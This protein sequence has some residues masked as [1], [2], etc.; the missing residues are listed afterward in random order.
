MLLYNIKEENVLYDYKPSYCLSIKDHCRLGKSLESFCASVG[1]SP[2]VI[3]QWYNEYP[4]FKDAIEMAPC[5]EL[6]YWEEQLLLCLEKRD[7]D[8]LQIIKSR[9]D[10][11]M[12]YVASPIKKETYN[13]LREEVGQQKVKSTGDLIK[14]FNLLELKRHDGKLP[15]ERYLSDDEYKLL[16]SGIG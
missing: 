4:D 9:I 1:V 13:N 14:D 3:N 8:S 7:R 10:N 16:K 15:E 12:K 11:L 5:L 6:L 2:K